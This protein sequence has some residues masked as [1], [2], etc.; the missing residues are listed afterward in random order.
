MLYE[1]HEPLAK[2]GTATFMA[3]PEADKLVNI[4]IGAQTRIIT[5]KNYQ[6]GLILALQN[7][8]QIIYQKNYPKLV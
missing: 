8:D 6:H 7:K 2:L 5:R 1:A 3:R 4:R